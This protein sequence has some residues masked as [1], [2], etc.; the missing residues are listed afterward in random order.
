MIVCK[1]ENFPY[2]YCYYFFFFL[3]YAKKR[4]VIYS[5]KNKK[6]KKKVSQCM[7]LFGCVWMASCERKKEKKCFFFIGGPIDAVFYSFFFILFLMPKIYTVKSFLS[8][9]DFQSCKL[10]QEAKQ[11]APP[12]HTHTNAS[13]S[14]D[15]SCHGCFCWL[16]FCASRSSQDTVSVFFHVIPQTFARAYGKK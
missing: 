3:K 15:S 2:Y 1:N 6:K 10:L 8:F 13:A 14:L 16:F 4:I 5:L 12:P 9:A 11:K 7:C